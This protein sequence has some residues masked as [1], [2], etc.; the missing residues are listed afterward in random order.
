MITEKAI[1]DTLKMVKE[2]YLT[3]MVNVT[4]N[5]FNIIKNFKNVH[6]FKN[7]IIFEGVEILWFESGE[8][9]FVEF[10]SWKDGYCALEILTEEERIIKNIIE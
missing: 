7:C 9:N 4:Y 5:D 1:K 8:S 6:M 3:G 2:K 10:R